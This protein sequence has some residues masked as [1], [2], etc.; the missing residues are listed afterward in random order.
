MSIA[1]F[2]PTPDQ[3]KACIQ[4]EAEIPPAAVLLAVHRRM[5]FQFV[6]GQEHRP[7]QEGYLLERFLDPN[8]ERG[9]A[10]I[11]IRGSSGVGK[12]HAIRWLEAKLRAMPEP[13][14]RHIILLPKSTSL[15]GAIKLILADLE[16]SRFEPIKKRLKT[17]RDH[18]ELSAVAIRLQGNLVIEINRRIEQSTAAVVSA[19]ARGESA[20][21]TDRKWQTHKTL[22]DVIL[23][24]DL[25]E[26][27]VG[28]GEQNEPKGVL[29]EVAARVLQEGRVIDEKTR[30]QFKPEDLIFEPEELQ[31][32]AGETRSYLQHLSVGG[33]QHRKDAIDLLNSVIDDAAN[34]LLD[35][36]DTGLKDIF[37][38]IRQELL[39][40]G[41]ELVVLVEDFAVLSGMQG[42]L[43]DALIKEAIKNGKQVR[44][45]MRTALA[46]T[47]GYQLPATVLTRA[48]GDFRLEDMPFQD[49]ESALD[50][51]VQLTGR[52]LN[53]ARVGRETL[54]KAYNKHGA[55]NQS[56]V[57]RFEDSI[58]LEDSDRAMLEA[59]GT[60]PSPDD[61][62]LF[63][64][65]RAALRQ[66]AILRF[67]KTDQGEQRIEFKPRDILKFIIRKTLLENG[68]DF[69]ISKFPPANYNE[70]DTVNRTPA[71]IEEIKKV[72]PDPA[73]RGRLAVLIRFW[74][75][76][77]TSPRRT[78]WKLPPQIPLAFGLR[79]IGTT[80]VEPK[81]PEPPKP[82][83]PTTGAVK[84][85]P[86]VVSHPDRPV[87]ATPFDTWRS[88]IDGWLT[89]RVKTL[90]QEEAKQLRHWIAGDVLSAINWD[91]E[92]LPLP[93]DQNLR[94][95]RD[96]VFLELA[97]GRGN[98]SEED[99]S[100]LAVSQKE[101]STTET[102]DAVGLALHALVRWKLEGSWSFDSDGSSYT[103][104]ANFILPKRPQALDFIRKAFAVDLLAPAARVLYL[105]T[106]LLDVSGAHSEKP[107]EYVNALFLKRATTTN[108][109][110]MAARSPGSWESLKFVAA[111]QRE[112]LQSFVL[113]F[114][115]ARTGGAGNPHA[116]DFHGL[117]SAL[118]DVR[119]KL[120]VSNVQLSGE[121]EPDF[122]PAVEHAKQLQRHFQTALSKQF[123][124]C[125]QRIV[126]CSK[127]LGKAPDEKLIKK[128]VEELIS[129]C[130]A[131]LGIPFDLCARLQKATDLFASSSYQAV[132]PLAPTSPLSTRLAFA[133]SVN[134]QHL[135][136]AEN[137]LDEFMKFSGA[138]ENKLRLAAISGGLADLK[139]EQMAFQAELSKT[140]LL[141]GAALSDGQPSD[142]NESPEKPGGKRSAAKPPA[143]VAPSDGVCL[144]LLK[145]QQLAQGLRDHAD[146]EK[147]KLK[148]ESLRTHRQNIKTHREDLE[149]QLKPWKLLDARKVP[150][151]G[152]P[153]AAAALR[154]GLNTLY[155]RVTQMSEQINSGQTMKDCL[156]GLTRIAN[157]Y[158][159]SAETAWKKYK[160][161]DFYVGVSIGLVKTFVGIEGFKVK[162][163]KLADA[164]EKELDP[165]IAKIPQSDE[166]WK[167]LENAYKLCQRLIKDLPFGNLPEDV[168]TF[169]E[170][171]VAGGA[172][173]SDMTK[174]V[175]DWIDEN[176]LEKSFVIRA[177]SSISQSDR[178][179]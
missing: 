161:S 148:A 175:K 55:K 78:D 79:D 174:D 77:P 84:P 101:L 41:K 72:E 135:S 54:E 89:G 173:V 113:R 127:E 152:K 153:L 33:G 88:C 93:A 130:S 98:A 132:E 162:A 144:L 133:A 30:L 158:E 64:F 156:A 36:G 10:L 126:R 116:I 42:A 92:L 170:A 119:T 94:S 141:V 46:V 9:T 179:F 86:P 114:V 3:V 149:K 34:Q 16:G 109:T 26:R 4:P 96:M 80:Y 20:A 112:R 118:G 140:A 62:F 131:S 121:F 106:R 178:F 91:L 21:D 11:T 5:E 146:Q 40:Q 59:F 31:N 134:E 115:G 103:R 171:T 1:K 129:K 154:D 165:R 138:V 150:G 39:S 60:N 18:V 63:P 90:P 169:L 65:N 168:R 52:Y 53:A 143:S 43:L 23:H 7:V 137:F 123:E 117:L 157:D 13:D 73:K 172:P 177:A 100:I 99:C 45:T 57:P 37:D 125:Q 85:P 105:G 164:I 76:N 139:S 120:T 167:D 47:T 87:P 19:R 27:W 2:W 12:S 44:C 74:G 24:P 70:A 28:V 166:E 6:E 61:F 145:C 8:V 75:D 58:D 48:T 102:A 155:V 108:V 83:Y 163:S 104:W 50:A 124:S 56:W 110:P 49:D 14:S 128:E 25:Y 107:E 38:D 151:L 159:L 68:S 122:K 35:L 176:N 22:R 32:V 15:K 51:I 97:A 29:A 81:S 66:L 69:H 147:H 67:R 136:V 111:E 17:A 160:E 71:V 95:F 82:A 142:A